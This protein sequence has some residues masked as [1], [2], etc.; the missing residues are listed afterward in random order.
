LAIL[1]D[2]PDCPGVTLTRRLTWRV[3]WLW[4]EKPA[5]GQVRQESVTVSLHQQLGLLEV[6]GEDV[7]VRRRPV[8]RVNCR[9]K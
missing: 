9:A 7:L 2:V 5:G 8:A 6:A 3:S 1:A 4:P